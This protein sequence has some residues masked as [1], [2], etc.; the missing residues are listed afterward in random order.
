M[1]GISEKENYQEQEHMYGKMAQHTKELLRMGK[2]MGKENGLLKVILITKNNELLCTM[3]I[4]KMTVGMGLEQWYGQLVGAMMVNLSSIL[5][6]DKER[7]YG[8]MGQH[9]REAGLTVTKMD[10]ESILVFYMEFR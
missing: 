5:D 10:L 9:M 1:L 3:A 6:M 7:W 2:R 4:L 8:I